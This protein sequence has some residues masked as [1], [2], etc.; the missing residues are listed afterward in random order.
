M[1]LDVNERLFMV[2]LCKLLERKAMAVC[3]LKE[4]KEEINL[5]ED[6]FLATI[7][8]MEKK[9]T[10]EIGFLRRNTIIRVKNWHTKYPEKDDFYLKIT[11]AG[12]LQI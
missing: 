8:S 12:L 7:L 10:I 11:K 4:F 1:L 2:S 6:F 5:D 9:K 3:S